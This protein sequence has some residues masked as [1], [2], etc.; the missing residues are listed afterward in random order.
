VRRGYAPEIAYDAVREY[1]RA[2]V[3]ADGPR[4]A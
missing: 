2:A 1:E 4:A 3:A